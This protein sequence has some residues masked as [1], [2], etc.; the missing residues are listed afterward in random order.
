MT[1]HVASFKGYFITINEVFKIGPACTVKC[2]DRREGFYE[3]T[4]C[5]H[6]VGS[7][8]AG[9]SSLFTGCTCPLGLCRDHFNFRLPSVMLVQRLK[10]F[11]FNYMLI[12]LTRYVSYF[13]T[14][15]IIV[16]V[17]LTLCNI[18]FLIFLRFF[19]IWATNFGEIKIFNGSACVPEARTGSDIIG[20]A[21]LGMTSNRSRD[22]RRITCNDK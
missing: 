19:L 7:V 9:V 22:T 6:F 1:N 10:K 18:L 13:T 17:W 5:L 15:C 20:T 11:V 16:F 2:K 14:D 3:S 4:S 12:V 8:P 21:L